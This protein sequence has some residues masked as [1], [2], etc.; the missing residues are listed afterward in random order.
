MPDFPGRLKTPRLAGAPAAPTVGEMYYNTG[1]NK[2]YWYNGTTWIDATGGGAPEVSIGANAPSPRVGE[3]IWIDTDEPAVRLIGAPP[4]VTSLPAS[5]TDGQEVYFLAD[6]GG[7]IIWHLR[8]RAASASTY[9][10]EFVGGPPLRVAQTSSAGIGP[11]AWI[12]IPNM[13]NLVVPLAGDYEADAKCACYNNGQAGNMGFGIAVGASTPGV[14]DYVEHNHTGAG[15]RAGI[16]TFATVTV[17]TAGG[18]I[19]CRG[20]TQVAGGQFTTFDQRRLRAY[21]VRV[22]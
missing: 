17:T 9:K 20:F 5:P 2:L 11:S 6:T 13:A 4:L 14:N 1:T 10:W 3:V 21:P 15:L 18:D 19:R 7:G 8:Y 16:A 12:D 22:G